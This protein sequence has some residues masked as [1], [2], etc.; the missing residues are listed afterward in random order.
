MMWSLPLVAI[1]AT[2]AS[3]KTCKPLPFD[4][5]ITFGD[6][7][8]DEGRLGYFI[9]NSGEG[10]P[11]GTL[12]PESSST[13]SGG[14]TWARFVSQMTGAKLYDYAVSGA[15][16]SNNIIERYFEYLGAPFPDVLGYEIPAFEADLAYVNSSTGTNTL[17][18]DRTSEN[19]VYA[20]WIGTNDLGA[21]AFLTDAQAE[22]KT[23]ADFIDCVW[24]VF[25]NIYATG[26]RRFVLLNEAPLEIS[27]MYAAPE[28]G[29]TY[30]NQFWTDKADYNMTAYEQKILEYTTLVNTIFEYGVH[31]EMFAKKRWPG[32]SFSI[33]D[34]HRLM[35]DIHANPSQ[36]LDLPTD[37]TGSYYTCEAEDITNCYTS[38]NDL[39]TF[40]WYDALHP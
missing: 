35:L 25:D 12:L 16:C 14:Y 2:V 3:A 23:I 36:Y 7:Y 22:G 17:Y 37:V 15:T 31:F 33:F 29:G 5:L 40:L 39:A 8:T 26:G 30:D 6:S 9:N 27:P 28:R 10:P 1:C 38:E 18:T 11:P 32:A 34:I 19:T 24:E 4:N 13:A 20:L 21:G